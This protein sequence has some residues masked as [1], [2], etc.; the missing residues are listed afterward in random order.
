MERRV[1]EEW[2]DLEGWKVL[3]E[4][5]VEGGSLEWEETLPPLHLHQAEAG[6]KQRQRF[7]ANVPATTA[8]PSSH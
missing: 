7:W 3:K 2:N 1:L 8:T 5:V 4:Y 6:H